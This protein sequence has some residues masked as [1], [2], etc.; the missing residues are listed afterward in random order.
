[1]KGM[2]MGHND[3]VSHVETEGFVN[4]PTPTIWPM[5]LAL[6]VSLA[7]AGLVTHW[8]ITLLGICMIVPSVVGWFFQ[9]LPHEQHEPVAVSTEVV[10]ISSDRIASAHHAIAQGRR[11]IEPLEGY[12]AM[13]GVKGGIAG[14]IAMTIPATIFGLVQYHSIWYPINLLAAG[15]FISWAGESDAFLVQFHWQGLVAGLAIHVFTSLL[16]GL[17]YGA[18]LPMF[19]RKPILT[20]GFVAPFLWTGILYT[21]LGILSPILN[22]RIHWGWFFLSQVAF[23][24]TAGF[25]VNLQVKVRSKSFRALPFA[26]RAG[27]ETDQS[28]DIEEIGKKED[29]R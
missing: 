7:V 6:G 27:L 5:I 16:V 17:L 4:L 1:M 26:V 24:L 3:T 14:G 25:V 29:P 2:A 11:E 12:S 22:Q 28:M 15:G 23:G 20:C 10:T 8:V 13:V 18:M 19:P 21:S 9:V